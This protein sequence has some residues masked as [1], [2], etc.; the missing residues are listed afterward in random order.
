MAKGMTYPAE[1]LTTDEVRSL[2]GACTTGSLGLRNR[3]LI[4]VLWRTGL[5]VSELLSLRGADVSGDSVRVLHGK[6]NKARTVGLDPESQ[7]VLALWVERRA[8]LGLSNR[9]PLFCDLKGGGLHTNAVRELLKRLA[10]KAG[11]VK[12]V[13]PHGFRHTFAAH[14]ARQLPIHFVQQALGHSN[15]AVTSRYV[16]HLGGAAVDAVR[17]MTW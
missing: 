15:L 16:S 6:G 14:A 2:L 8:S 3:A 4:M 10:A 9:A 7:A 12:R 13:H 17:G 11:V 1:I 5:R